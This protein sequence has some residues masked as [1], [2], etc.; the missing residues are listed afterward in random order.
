[1]HTS[2]TIENIRQNEFL[3]KVPAVIYPPFLPLELIRQENYRDNGEELESVSATVGTALIDIL[4][5]CAPLSM[6]TH[7][8]HTP[9]TH[10][11]YRRHK[12]LMVFV[13]IGCISYTYNV[14]SVCAY[15]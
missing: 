1:M 3:L 13:P 8:A 7:V 10:V 5:S 12:N 11:A 6:R 4:W 2:N 14:P 15:L 9:G